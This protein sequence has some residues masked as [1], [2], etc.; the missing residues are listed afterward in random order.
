MVLI[1]AEQF[2]QIRRYYS[3]EIS[4]ENLENGTA[5]FYNADHDSHIIACKYRSIIKYAT[6]QR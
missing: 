2:L 5:A 4:N 3:K 6:L 1:Y